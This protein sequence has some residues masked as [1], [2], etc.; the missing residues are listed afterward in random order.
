M[1]FALTAVD[2]PLS[3]FHLKKT[4]NVSTFGVT[5]MQSYQQ[6]QK[7]SPLGRYLSWIVW[8]RGILGLEEAE[9]DPPDPKKDAEEPLNLKQPRWGKLARKFWHFDQGCWR[10]HQ[11]PWCQGVCGH[12]GKPLQVISE[13]AQT[14]LDNRKSNGGHHHGL[15]ARLP[16][17][18]CLGHQNEP[19]LI[20]LPW[21]YKGRRALKSMI[22][23]EF[24]SIH[25]GGILE[26]I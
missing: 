15:W 19:H 5:L 6:H 1:Y 26:K 18:S 16:L 17:T 20:I 25:S 2:I 3:P 23:T 13:S 21:L 12:S 4:A 9:M 11:W 24:P 8:W 22:I 14:K 10:W 7:I